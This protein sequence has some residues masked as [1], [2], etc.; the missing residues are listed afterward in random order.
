MGGT[1]SPVK[2]E[3]RVSLVKPLTAAGGTLR[4]R[5]IRIRI[6]RWIRGHCILCLDPGPE[7]EKVT[8]I[9]A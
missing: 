3:P 9:E 8:R 1:H 7:N 2:C 5:L 6:C 4:W